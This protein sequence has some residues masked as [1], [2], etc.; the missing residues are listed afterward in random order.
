M[1][2]VRISVSFIFTNFVVFLLCSIWTN[3]YIKNK[4]LSLFLSLVLTAGIYC[5]IS[6]LSEKKSK[7][8]QAKKIKQK[9]LE[10][11]VLYL[12]S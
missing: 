3:F 6:F 1:K 2:S 9:N 11:F 7:T 5:G 4:I 12:K 8:S 10:D